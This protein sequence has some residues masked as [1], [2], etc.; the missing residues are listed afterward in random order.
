[1][2][3]LKEAKW[4]LKDRFLVFKG[5]LYILPGILRCEAVHLNHD[6]LIAGHFGYLRILELMHWKYYWPG[7]NRDIKEYVDTCD[8]CHRIK[9]VRYKPYGTLNLLPPSRGPF[10]D[11][12]MDFIM[13][14]PSCE[15]QRTVYD[16]IFLV[17]CRYTKMA[18]YI[19]ARIDWTAERLA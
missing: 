14:M 3:D 11:L 12:T 19:V 8:T 17:M 5:K 1:M 9:S 16:S 4:Q 18:R 6:D 15:Y 2:S 10:T 7:I 13:D